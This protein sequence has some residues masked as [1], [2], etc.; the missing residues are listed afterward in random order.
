VN[1]GP[2]GNTISDGLNA[3]G[4][5]GDVRDTEARVDLGARDTGM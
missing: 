1:I 3:V 4:G 2:T 5:T